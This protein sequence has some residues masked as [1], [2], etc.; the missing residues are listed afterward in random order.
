MTEGRVFIHTSDL[1]QRWGLATRTVQRLLRQGKIPSVTMG[2]QR[3]IPLDRVIQMER[4]QLGESE[5]VE[6]GE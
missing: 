1:A 3:L 4:E 5:P 6:A 2:R